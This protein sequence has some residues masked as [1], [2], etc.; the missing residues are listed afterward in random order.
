MERINWS[1]RPIG[2]MYWHKKKQF[3]LDQDTDSNWTMFAVES[4]QFSYRIGDQ[5]GEAGFG[6]IVVCPPG[7][8]FHRRTVTPLT[9][10][11]VKFAWELDPAPDEAALLGGRWSVKDADRLMSTYR[12]MKEIGSGIREQPMLGRMKHMLEDLWRL[13]EMER[14]MASASMPEADAP[15]LD[16]QQAREWLMEHACEPLAM[17][18]LAE[19]LGL[20]PVQLTR[21]FRAAYR[22][23]PS[24]FVTGIR[25][26]RACRLLEETTKPLEWIAQQCGYENGFY[27]SRVFSAKLGMT[28]SAHRKLHRV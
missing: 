5:A 22:T 10:H 18:E 28:P 6:D 26:G 1:V 3:L 25:L 9:F 8:A 16:M 13:L 19:M 17:R 15:D 14:S 21:K 2:Y 11:F 20:S 27:L 24:D 7:V 4:G 12:Y 23:T